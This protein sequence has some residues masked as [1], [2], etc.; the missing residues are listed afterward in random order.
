VA[1]NV[2]RT[3]GEAL[4]SFAV[5]YV[6]WSYRTLTRDQRSLAAIS[7]AGARRAELQAAA[8]SAADSTLR[9][10]RL[11]NSGTVVSIASDRTKAGSWVI[12]THE[13]TTGAGDYEGLPSTY[14]V[15]VA[16]LARVP[17]GYAVSEWLP[18]S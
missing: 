14:H 6:N 12:V 1:S 5:L 2:K 17:G 10:S 9:A 13:R 16:R 15:T 18:Q 4:C 11:A 3:P 7:V 8:S